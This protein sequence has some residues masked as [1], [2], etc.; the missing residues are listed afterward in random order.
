M[1]DARGRLSFGIKPKPIG[2]EVDTWARELFP[3]SMRQLQVVE[4]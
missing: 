2:I 3:G 1:R 4:G